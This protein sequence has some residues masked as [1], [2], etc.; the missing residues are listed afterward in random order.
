[1]RGGLRF[2][3][4]LSAALVLGAQPMAAFAAGFYASPPKLNASS[5]DV[6]IDSQGNA[7]FT[8]T[9]N[10][11]TTQDQ[12]IQLRERTAAGVLG[13]TVTLSK[14]G[15][16][17]MPS[18]LAVNG[19]GAAV[20]V[21]QVHHGDASAKTPVQAR[22]RSAEGTLGPIFAVVPQPGRN[23]SFDFANPGVVLDS[24]GNATFSWTGLDA[25]Q[26]RRIY[27]RRRSAAGALG[28]ILAISLAGASDAKMAVDGNG[29]TVFVWVWNDGQ[30]HNLI[31]AR[32]LSAGGTFGSIKIIGRGVQGSGGGGLP[33]GNPQVAVD[34]QGNA[35]IAWEQPDGQGPCG[36]NGC[37]KVLA[38]T[39]SK[40]GVVGTV[41]QTLTTT[42][43][44]GFWPQVAMDAVGNAVVTWQHNGL[45]VRGRLANGT[46]G[47]LQNFTT[48][49]DPTPPVL[50]GDPTGRTIAVWGNAGV[51]QARARSAAGGMGP[52]HSYAIGGQPAFSGVLA[53]GSGGNTMVGW[54]QSD[55]LGQCFGGTSCNRVGAAA[56]P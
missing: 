15:H 45:E 47:A 7:V 18:H 32:Q 33:T 25:S 43:S 5:A 12:L 2:S 16:D 52:V 46:L 10:D 14:T 55:G 4:S 53:V 39:L 9:I 34:A 50:K 54:G 36:I 48:A 3:L 49:A 13:T 20:V 26:K 40:S 29:A 31:E 1:M 6:G 28:P 24:A 42:V 30:G 35:L 44:G 38:R 56:G 21:W 23:F 37:P 22:A 41:S 51:I 19:D 17:A 8:W 27:A 11:P